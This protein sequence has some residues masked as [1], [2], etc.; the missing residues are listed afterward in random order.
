MRGRGWRGDQ[1]EICVV[2]S[3]GSPFRRKAGRPTAHGDVITVE[4]MPNVY[5][6]IR[7]SLRERYPVNPYVLIAMV[8]I[9]LVWSRAKSTDMLRYG[10]QAS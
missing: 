7:S 10:S 4:E 9:M 5:D 6:R 3:G 2:E 8:A 1:E